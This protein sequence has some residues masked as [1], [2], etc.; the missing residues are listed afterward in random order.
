[1]TSPVNYRFDIFLRYHP[2]QRRW[3]QRLAERLDREGVRVWFDRWML[4]PGSDRRLESQ[5]G[6]SESRWGGSGG[7]S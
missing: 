3:T 6:I 2:V 7:F 4:P 5:V 1:M